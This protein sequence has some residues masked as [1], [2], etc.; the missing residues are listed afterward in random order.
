MTD[1]RKAMSGP[2]IT[3]KVKSLNLP[4]R[5]ILVCSSGSMAARGIRDAN[6]ID[7]FANMDVYNELAKDPRWLKRV[8]EPGDEPL[9]FDVF[10]V[11]NN[12]DFGK[13][14][15]PKFSELMTR[16]F[17]VDDVAFESLEDVRRSKLDRGRPQDQVDVKLIDKYLTEHRE[18]LEYLVWKS[19][20]ESK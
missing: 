14:F 19:K 5:G 6:D 10:E 17:V 3:A 18:G 11:H 1:E 2:E 15:K 13:E 7:I 12:W 20:F 4:R 9:A 8:K 16:A